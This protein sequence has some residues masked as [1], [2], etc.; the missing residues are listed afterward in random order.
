MEFTKLL[1]LPPRK[2]HNKYLAFFA[3]MSPVFEVF[4]VLFSM[5]LSSRVICYDRNCYVIIKVMS[6]GVLK[7]MFGEFT[8]IDYSF[9]V[10]PV[11]VQT[12]VKGCL[13]L[14]NI[15]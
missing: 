3:K 14:S 8:G 2:R 6:C 11:I 7:K 5:T 10:V 12:D 1:G 15:L 9:N 4:C 13:A